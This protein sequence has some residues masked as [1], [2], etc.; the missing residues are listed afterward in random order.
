MNDRIKRDGISNATA[1]REAT[2]LKGVLSRAS[3]WDLIKYNQLS[4]LR[5]LPESEKRERK[6]SRAVYK[7]LEGIEEKDKEESEDK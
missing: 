7:I 3:E 1:N 5:L 4:R 2:F 6:A